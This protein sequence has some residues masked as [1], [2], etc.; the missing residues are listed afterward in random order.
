MS[1]AKQ[2]AINGGKWMTTSTA[3]STVFQFL[4][5]AVLARLLDPSDFGIV[6]VSTLIIAFFNIFA[7]LG[8]SNSIIYKQEVDR[9]VLSSLYL[10]NITLGIL[11]FLIIYVSSPLAVAYYKEPR[12]D[13]VIKLS[14][15]YF[16]IVYAGQIHY[17]LLQKELR[18]RSVASIDIVGN[19]IGLFTTIG[20]AYAGFKELSLIYGQLTL[21]ASKTVLQIGYGSEFFKP[22][23]KFNF[24]LIK[25]HLKFGMYNIGDG[26]VGF[27]QANSDNILVGGMLGVKPLGYYTLASQLAVFPISRLNPIVLQ[28]AYPILAKMKENDDELKKSYLTIL[29]LISYVNLPLLAGLYI[30]ADSVVPLFYGPGWEETIGLIRI[31][32]FVSLF[33]SLSNPLFTLAFSKGKPKRS[34]RD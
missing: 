33:S 3:I 20:L 34:P 11:I 13:Q 5:V 25:D 8:F 23:F 28:V 31:F 7:N 14:S 21:Q 12:L 27:V 24:K 22:L 16:L 19:F 30:T 18:F 15:F 32:V 6:S 10:L 9:H 4:Q 17:F 29:D 2:Q 1:S 26:V